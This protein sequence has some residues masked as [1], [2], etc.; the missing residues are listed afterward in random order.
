MTR[1]QMPP[2]GDVRRPSP[3]FGNHLAG[4]EQSE[5]DP[6]TGES[7]SFAALFGARRDVVILRQR[8]PLHPAAVVYDGQCR[9]AGIGQ[10]LDARRAGVEC[11][12]HDFGEDRLLERTG[13]G[14]AKVFEEMVKVDSRFTHRDILPVGRQ[15]GRRCLCRRR[16]SVFRRLW[17]RG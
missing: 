14:V 10:Q 5:L 2:G 11:V 6:H 17:R 4:D 12:G 1:R 15:R 8:S 9:R 7:D 16:R 13:V 3:G